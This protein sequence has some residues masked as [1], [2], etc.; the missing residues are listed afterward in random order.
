MTNSRD[1][2]EGAQTRALEGAVFRSPS[3]EQRTERSDSDILVSEYHKVPI[4]VRAQAEAWELPREEVQL[5]A[6]IA[7]GEGGMVYQCRW[8]GLDC[9][10]KMLATDSDNSREFSDMINELSTISHL[11]HPNLVLFLGACTRER[12]LILASEFLSGGNLEEWTKL[13]LQS[14]PRSKGRAPVDVALGWCIDLARAVCYLHNC[15]TPVIHRDLKPANLLLTD[16][17]R[18]KVSDFGLS[19][20]L[21]KN[22]KG[23]VYQMTGNKGTIRYMAPEV[24]RSDPEYNEKVDLYSSGMIFWYIATGSQPFAEIEVDHIAEFAARKKIR[25]P[26]DDVSNRFL[27]QMSQLISR[28]WD[29]EP[30]LRPSGDVVVEELELIS[31]SALLKAKKDKS[32]CLVQ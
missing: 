32:K 18:L 19:K 14:K 21:Q 2:S 25:P 5:L 12:P 11:R 17:L 9:V 28:C 24:I 23:G 26:L 8:R 15:T 29:D 4:H 31:Q 13:Q 1:N 30:A 27:P 7:E 3:G 16:D 22:Q 10:A 6:L 20:T